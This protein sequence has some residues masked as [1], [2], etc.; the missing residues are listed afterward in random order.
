MLC[1]VCSLCC[2][3][4]STCTPTAGYYGTGGGAIVETG[5][6]E[7]AG[8]VHHEQ[9]VIHCSDTAVIILH[10]FLSNED[11]LFKRLDTGCNSGCHSYSYG[12]EGSLSSRRFQSQRHAA[13]ALLEVY[14]QT[15]PSDLLIM[16]S[17]L[18][19]LTC[20]HCTHAFSMNCTQDPLHKV[21]L[22][23]QLS[24]ALHYAGSCMSSTC[25]L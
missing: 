14:L 1:L 7:F 4:A 24:K 23:V 5:T 16:L 6:K 17:E 12:Q 18:Q 3:S 20:I 13:E 15:K 22:T 19:V 9:P 11:E 21:L 2:C 10:G 25:Q 8:E